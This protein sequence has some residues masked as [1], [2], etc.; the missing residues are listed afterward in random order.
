MSEVRLSIDRDEWTQL[1]EVAELVEARLVGSTLRLIGSDST[2]FGL[3][4]VLGKDGTMVTLPSLRRVAES[5]D[6]G[7]PIRLVEQAALLVRSADRCDLVLHG[8][9]VQRLE[10]SSGARFIID[11]MPIIEHHAIENSEQQAVAEVFGARG[12]DAWFTM[13]PG[14]L[15]ASW[16]A[17]SDAD[18]PDGID[19]GT[20]E[21]LYDIFDVWM[22]SGASW[23]AVMR[24]REIGFPSDL[25]LE[26]TAQH[27]G[28]FQLYHKDCGGSWSPSIV[29]C[30][31]CT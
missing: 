17:D 6:L 2:G 19:L 23:H 13:E 11:E 14:E 28:W 4:T 21:K 27:R 16:D 26:G 31:G 30:N 22:E 10:A 7:V 8:D 5:F 25:Y 20:L 9:G 3:W 1:A 15:L 12:S 18:A 24:Q 29:F